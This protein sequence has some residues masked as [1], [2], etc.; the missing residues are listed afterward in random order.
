M[1]KLLQHILS[2]DRDEAVSVPIQDMA[3]CRLWCASPSREQ[4]VS[5]EDHEKFDEVLSTWLQRARPDSLKTEGRRHQT[6]LRELIDRLQDAKIGAMS[7]DELELLDTVYGLIESATHRLSFQRILELIRPH[8]ETI[9][10]RAKSLEAKPGLPGLSKR[11]RIVD[12]NEISRSPQKEIKVLAGIELPSRGPFLS[13]KGHLRV[14]GDVPDNATV[15]VESGHCVIDGFVFG[16]VAATGHCEVRENISGVIVVRDGDVR[17]RG[18]ID[19][20]MAVSKCGNVYCRSAQNPK[21][22]FAGIHIDIRGDTNQGKF[23]SQRLTI[24]SVAT[25]GEYHVGEAFK[26]AQARPAES[27]PLNI[28]FRRRFSCKDYGETP[29]REMIRLMSRA[30]RLREQLYACKQETQNAAREAEEYASSALMY[31]LGGDRVKD[32][33]EELVTAQRRLTILNRVILSLHGLYSQA[34]TGLEEAEFGNEEAGEESWDDNWELDS[35]EAV[36]TDLAEEHE[37]LND[38]RRDLS[39][40]EKDHKNISN[41]LSDLGERLSHW[42]QEAR[43]LRKKMKK[44]EAAIQGTIGLNALPALASGK[45][46]KVM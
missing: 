7:R 6:L 32:L 1:Q 15:V 39:S 20:A 26:A 11:L 37:R 19:N 14:L 9:R 18:I 17:A 12:E 43:D 24:E 23:I 36:D 5:K 22:V 2:L 21:L 8:V 34:E 31:L 4:P 25:G 40:A 16:R 10:N 44:N 28:V 45:V 27:H 29:G 3:V 33:L 41:L 30:L 13:H 46:L 42:V 38:Y 35:E